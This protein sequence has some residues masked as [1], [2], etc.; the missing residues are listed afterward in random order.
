METHVCLNCKSPIEGK[1]CSNCGQKT[2]T[3][4]IT[5]KHFLFHDIVH[6]VWHLDKGILFTL[7]QASI[8]PG[9]AALDYIAGK[10]VGYYN[11][12][13]LILILIGL[14]I[15]IDSIYMSSLGKYVSFVEPDTDK[16]DEAAEK[17]YEIISTYI[18]F[19]L[20][21]SIPAYALNSYILFNKKRLL[22]SEH[23]IIFGMF[24]TGFIIIFLLE[25]FLMFAEFIESIAF[26]RSFS[27]YL[28]PTL[29]LIYILN[30]LYGA[31]GK[32]Y[33]KASF[34]FRTLLYITLFVAE[35]KLASFAVQ[36]YLKHYYL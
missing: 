20:L 33:S 8:R 11:I 1:F 19:F 32:D 31:F 22:Y 28:T 14:G 9:K 13:Y 17:S 15:F 5:L 3:H 6:G 35:I 21:L 12:F 10:R 34:A 30:G 7:K 4:R 26:L 25:S 23:L 29:S 24:L 36:Y 18:K 2:D 16:Y 27:F